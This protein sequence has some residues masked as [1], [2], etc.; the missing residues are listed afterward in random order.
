MWLSMNEVILGCIFCLFWCNVVFHCYVS[1]LRSALFSEF[2][3]GSQRLQTL[4]ALL[5]GHGAFNS[6]PNTFQSAMILSQSWQ[7]LM[8]VGPCWTC[9]S[10]AIVFVAGFLEPVLSTQN[11]H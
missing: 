11:P 9:M 3:P 4:P 5:Q 8:M 6:I 1:L 10:A 2:L 7:L